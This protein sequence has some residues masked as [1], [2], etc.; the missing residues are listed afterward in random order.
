MPTCGRCGED[1]PSRARFCLACGG[2]LAQVRHA[3]KI[4]TLLFADIVG[5]TRLAAAMDSEAFSRLVGRFFAEMRAV[6]ERHGGTVE[7]YAGDEIIAAFGLAVAHEDDAARAVRAACEMQARLAEMNHELASVWRTRVEVRIGINT[8]EVALGDA[9]DEHN[10]LGDPANVAAGLEKAAEPNAILIS[11]STYRLVRNEVDTTGP[12]TVPLKGKPAPVTGYRVVG[13]REAPAEPRIKSALVGR[14]AELLLLQQSFEL[15]VANSTSQLITVLGEPGVGKSRLVDELV[16][17]IETRASVFSGRCL[18]YGDAIT[19]W[20]LVEVV[21]QAAGVTGSD[22]PD[23]VRAKLLRLVG[24]RPNADGIVDRISQLLGA[25]ETPASREEIFGAV[26]RFFEVLAA[27]NPVLVIVD[28]IHWAEALLL[29][30]IEHVVGASRTSP[31]LFLC[32]ARPELL[33]SR[34]T[35]GGGK[36][37]ATSLLLHPLGEPESEELL[38]NLVRHPLSDALRKRV[39]DTAGGNPLFI[40]ETVSMLIDEGRVGAQTQGDDDEEALPIPPTIHALLTARFELLADVA[41]RALQLGAVMGKVFPA[42][43]LVETLGS[44]AATGL[45]A[46]SQKDF[47]L[48]VGERFADDDMYMFR[49]LLIRDAA[50]QQMPKAERANAHEWYAGWLRRVLADRLSEYEEIIGYHLEQAHLYLVELGTEQKRAVELGA[51]GAEVLNSA[52]VRAL[53]R[54]DLTA[55]AKLLGRAG[56]LLPPE[57]PKR[58]VLLAELGAILQDQ[59]E[60]EA[61]RRVLD[62]ALALA[63]LS[64]D[65]VTDARVRLGLVR[66][67]FFTAPAVEGDKVRAEAETCL[68]IL[69]AA[70]DYAGAA[71]ACYLLSLVD[72]SLGHSSDAEGW[73]RR[74]ITLA[75][76]AEDWARVSIYRAV[77]LRSRSWGATPLDKVIEEA[78]DLLAWGRDND[79]LRAVIAALRALG[80]SRAALGDFARASEATAAYRDICTELHLDMYWA[81]GVLDR[82]DSAVFEG[83]LERAEGDLR[84]SM[85]ILESNREVGVLASVL[86]ELANVVVARGDLEEAERTVAYA[87]ELASTDDF[88]AQ[89][90]WRRAAAKIA[91]QKGDHDTA[92]RLAR[93]AVEI[94]TETE[95]LV[96]A[97]RSLTDLARILAASGGESEAAARLDQARSLCERKGVRLDVVRLDAYMGGG[98]GSPSAS[99]RR[100]KA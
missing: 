47:I 28:D 91:L 34:P 26:R 89:V 92:E 7:G 95:D 4:V 80:R 97:A 88:H 44:D 54:G 39:L 17:Q 11:E 85:R 13:L 6:I 98:F 73:S 76:R 2:E 45:G 33:D 15:V 46:L 10:V 35:W 43:A 60:L 50:Y 18:P 86:A 68:T 53:H 83:D 61:A 79:H 55:A 12:L 70:E 72:D 1:N 78:E 56:D 58:A 31:L 27:T 51:L 65:A 25:A 99:H 19:Y 75:E 74:A 38:V 41:R 29:D 8:G 42:A 9:A 87:A 100:A 62:D 77:L 36:P 59:G 67:E 66:L 20:P 69:E 90:G 14:D 64:K 93:E 71:S 23:E 82:A 32:I 3:R 48:A 63:A 84:E 96:T 94:A 16:G 5:S 81:W 21:E 57:H 52:G 37:N 40:E 24:D 22:V 49:H 30:L